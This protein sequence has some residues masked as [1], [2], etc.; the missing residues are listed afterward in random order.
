MKLPTPLV[1]TNDDGIDAPGIRALQ[2]AVGGE[3]ILIAPSGPQSGCSHYLTVD[4]PIRV[5]HRSEREI[6]VHGTPGDCVRL[7]IKVFA[8]GVRLVLAGINQGGN[9]GHDIY[10]SGTVAAAREAAF[11]GVPS[12]A[13]SQYFNRELSL[14]WA[15]SAKQVARILPGLLA[16][17][18][19]ERAFWNVNLPH[20]PAQS[21][22]PE[23][24]FCDYCRAPLPTEYTHGQDGYLYVRGLYQSRVCEAHT[25]VGI[26]FGGNISATLMPL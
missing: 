26:C 16:R 17:E 21:S 8:P 14:N 6:V 9:L 4:R 1:L 22:E 23:L 12:I 18:L 15:W 5:E 13:F 7:A 10:L 3:A 24:Q 20:L 19:P 25:D 2:Q 11:H